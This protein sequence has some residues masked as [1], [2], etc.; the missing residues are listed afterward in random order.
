MSRHGAVEL[1]WAD[2]THTFR[3]GL[4]HLEELEEKTDTSIFL[5]ARLLS[6]EVRAART[7]QIRETL[8]LGLI[9]NA[10]LRLRTKS[11]LAG[12]VAV[13]ALG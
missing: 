13:A 9:G 2:G 5:L 8:R 7:V 1:D 4:E 6:P 11:V 3:L 10:A 12:P